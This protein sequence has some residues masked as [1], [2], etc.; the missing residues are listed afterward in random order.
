V[1][2]G[3]GAGGPELIGVGVGP[4]DPE[5]VTVAAVAALRAAAVVVVPVSTPARGDVG[6]QVAGRA[7]QVVRAHLGPDRVVRVPFAM[8]ERAGVTAERSRAWE[9]AAQVVLDAFSDGAST[10]AFATLGDPNV[11]STFT[12][13]AATVREQVPR[14]RIRTIPGITAMQDLACRAGVALCEGRE[15]LTLVP[16]SAG[17][18]ALEAALGRDGTVVVYKGSIGDGELLEVLRRHGRLD[19]AVV[20]VRLGMDGERL[21]PAVDWA[22]ATGATA[23]EVA[24]LPYLSTVL[25]PAVREGHGG[26]L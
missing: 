11:F 2:G 17:A 6:A 8:S 18:E 16:A 1:A 10:V 9:A 13:L 23:G 4:G 5:L 14:V 24:R 21:A 3:P 25:V 15:V 26:K 7:E 19:E 20:G 12:Y 22:P